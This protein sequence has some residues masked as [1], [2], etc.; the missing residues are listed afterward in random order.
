[1]AI[2]QDKE[3]LENPRQQVLID[4]PCRVL[5][6]RRDRDL[7]LD[8][9]SQFALDECDQYLERFGRVRSSAWKSNKAA[10]WRRAWR[11]NTQKLPAE[12]SMGLGDSALIG[13]Y[14]IG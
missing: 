3:V 12:D 4:A 11:R 10:G 14:G 8:K 13:V 6:L 5:A 9:L 2:V 1:M 7:R